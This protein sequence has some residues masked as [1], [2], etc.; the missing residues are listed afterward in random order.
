MKNYI[1]HFTLVATTLLLSAC[2]AADPT[3]ET[4]RIATDSAS[5]QASTETKKTPAACTPKDVFILAETDRATYRPGATVHITSTIINISNHA[6]SLGVGPIA[7]VSPLVSVNDSSENQ[8]WSNCYVND[9]HGACYEFWTFQTLNAGA[10][11]SRQFTWDQGTNEPGDG[12]VH[13]IPDG[14]YSVTTSY[15]SV[16]AISDPVSIKI[17]G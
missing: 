7:G 15:A 9:Q 3:A 5:V 16:G 8:L 13:R 2:G 1:R 6:C 17:T 12:A 14:V 4:S 10:I 11:W